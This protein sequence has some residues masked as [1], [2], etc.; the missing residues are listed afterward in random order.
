[1]FCIKAVIK[2][3]NSA[4]KLVIPKLLICEIFGLKQKELNE[5]ILRFVNTCCLGFL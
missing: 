3:V 2:S 5:C 4:K 1:M